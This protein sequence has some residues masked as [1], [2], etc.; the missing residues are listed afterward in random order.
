MVPKMETMTG[1]EFT[2]SFRQEQPFFG[3]TKSLTLKVGL[4]IKKGDKK[5]DLGPGRYSTGS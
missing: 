1:H 3:E 4:V 2:T 5:A